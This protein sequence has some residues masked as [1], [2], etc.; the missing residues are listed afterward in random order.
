VVQDAIKN[1]SDTQHSQS[2]N[3]TKTRR[4]GNLEVLGARGRARAVGFRTPPHRGT[5]FMAP[6][7][8]CSE[9]RKLI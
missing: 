2:V 1:G 6:Q 9:S 4:L 3:K 7:P 5:A 8:L